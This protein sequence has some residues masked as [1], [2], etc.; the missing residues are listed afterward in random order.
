[1]NWNGKKVFLAGL[2]MVFFSGSAFGQSESFEAISAAMTRK[3]E[4]NQLVESL[5]DA[6]GFTIRDNVGCYVF[7]G[8]NMYNQEIPGGG[9]PSAILQKQGEN[10]LNSCR[11]K[12][13]KKLD[14]GDFT[15]RKKEEIAG[16]ITEAFEEL[17]AAKVV[18]DRYTDMHL[19][20]ARDGI[21]CS[22]GLY[23]PMDD[24]LQILD[25]TLFGP[26]IREPTK[27][28]RDPMTQPLVDA[29]LGVYVKVPKSQDNPWGE[30]GLNGVLVS[31]GELLMTQ[32][33]GVCDME[34]GGFFT[35]PPSIQ[36][37]TEDFS[38]NIDF[39]LK[40]TVFFMKKQRPAAGE[41]YVTRTHE[42]QTYYGILGRCPT[43]TEIQEADHDLG[44][45]VVYLKAKGSTLLDAGY[46]PIQLANNIDPELFQK[47][48]PESKK[49]AEKLKWR[50]ATAGYM[51][52][53]ALPEN[54]VQRSWDENRTFELI[55]GN[56]LTLKN[57]TSGR[58]SSDHKED[59][60][61]YTGS[62]LAGLSGAGI[63][64]CKR[65]GTGCLVFASHA[66]DAGVNL[67]KCQG[68][69]VSKYH[70][71]SC[72]NSGKLLNPYGIANYLMSGGHS[73]GLVDYGVWLE[74]VQ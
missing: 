30:T 14:E 67:R 35:S 57:E 47:D 53:D 15:S 4:A 26:D 17:Y 64:D 11:D 10:Y 65:N 24:S 62:S 23:R 49:F 22:D 73:S 5:R 7:S 16:F 21:E 43:R 41:R 29:T 31:N 71:N 28:L 20:M 72:A 37:T 27:G 40:N 25:V 61:Q 54:T 9:D 36:T 13:L 39:D 45:D 1:M 33:H 60:V 66:A 3:A 32:L 8:F 51:D 68:R 46:T 58:I 50:M 70:S 18:G 44:S 56:D 59:M 38:E 74:Q 19:E 12:Y 48:T 34:K 52:D 55:Q 42:G 69:N 63:S 6:I 2:S